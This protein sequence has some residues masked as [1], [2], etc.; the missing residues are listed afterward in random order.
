MKEKTWC[1]GKKILTKVFEIQIGYWNEWQY[2]DIGCRWNRK[3][4]H[5]G[6]RFGIEL[7]GIY[8]YL[9][10]Y[11]IRHWNDDENKWEN[12]L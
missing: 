5:A 12:L 8:L 10:F 3:C 7:L 4:D 6:L 2:F 11:D 1:V 9:E